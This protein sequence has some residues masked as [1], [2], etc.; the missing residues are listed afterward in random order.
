[1]TSD[2]TFL[3]E[4]TRQQLEQ[5]LVLA[6][7]GQTPLP[8]VSPDEFPYLAI[9]RVEGLLDKQTRRDLYSVCQQLVSEF[10]RT[11][12]GRLVGEFVRTEKE[13]DEYLHSLL[14]LAVKL[15]IREL[16]PS[17]AQL[18]QKPELFG[19]LAVPVQRL[20][21]T[22]LVEFRTQPPAFW[23]SILPLNPDAFAGVVFSG[24]FSRSPKQAMTVLQHLPTRTPVVAAASGRLR[25]WIE[26]LEPTDRR[27]AEAE[28]RQLLP[29]C[30][31]VVR[32]M[33]GKWVPGE[34]SAKPVPQTQRQNNA[35]RAIGLLKILT[36]P[37]NTELKPSNSRLAAA[38]A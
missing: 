20:V 25:R 1:M 11:G 27:A 21:L 9:M 12:K 7:N 30:N 29:S 5:W 15:Q 23:Q 17:L 22:T 18:A 19:H 31:E 36:K 4:G 8:R 33:F 10:V 14:N 37:M 13:S 28:L 38:A 16:A 6:L 35:H 34:I 32:E 26:T 2:Y 24:V 3:N